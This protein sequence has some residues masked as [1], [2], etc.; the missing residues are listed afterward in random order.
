MPID[1]SIA[2]GVKAPQFESPVNALSQ[3]LQVQA[4]QQ[5]N[6]LGQAKLDEYQRGADRT[7]RLNSL[8]AN[9]KPDAPADEQVG[10][11]TRGGF[12]PEARSL[13]ESSAKVAKEKRDGEKAQWEAMGQK[14][15]LGARILGSVK[16]QASYDAARVSAQQAGLDVSNM[17]SQYDPAFVAAKRTEGL[18]TLE[19]F[20]QGWKQKGFDLELKKADEQTRHNRAV[21]NN[22]AGQLAVSQGQLGVA[23]GNLK[24]SQARETREAA[25]GKVPSGYHQGPDGTLVAIPGGPADPSNKPPTEFQ[26]KSAAFGARAQQADKILTELQGKYSPAGI[27]TKNALSDVWVVGG[28]LGAAANGNLSDASQRAEQAQRDFINAVLRQESGA[29]IGAGEFDNARKQ[30]FPQVNDGPALIAQK[31]ANRRLAVQGLLTNA[32]HAAFSASPTSAAP[33]RPA[34]APQAPAPQAPPATNS[35]GWTL[36]VDAKGNRAYVSPDGKQYEEVQ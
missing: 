19:Q 33:A 27:N 34:P 26:G 20:E 1:P 32:G 36:H 22:S 12:L 30:Y 13:A 23:Q 2:M 28:A 17:P 35:K 25:A 24:V 29:A 31:A 14:L 15:A 10:A 7:N 6:Q 5:Q 9:I 16:D 11:L 21:E 18:T 8:L 3:L 4:T